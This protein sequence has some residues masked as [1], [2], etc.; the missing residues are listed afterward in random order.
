MSGFDSGPEL[1][2]VTESPADDPRDSV[3]FVHGAYVGAWCW[4]EHFLPALA[5]RGYAAH[6]VSLRGHGGSGGSL[7]GA[8]LDDFVADV[9]RAV[10]RLDSNPVLVGH[11]MGGVVVQRY[12]QRYDAPAAAL[13]ATIP[14]Q[15]MA[16]LT[17]E[18]ACRD[19]V[20]WFQ[21]G[22]LQT[23]GPRLTSPRVMRRA[24]F[25]DDLSDDRVDAY[26]RL[27]QRESPRVLAELSGPA[28]TGRVPRGLPTLVLGAADDAIVP[29]W[30]TEA[31]ARA[32][33]TDPT[34]VEDVAHAV[35]LDT[36]WER[37]E[38]SLAGWLDRLSTAR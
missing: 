24:L 1:E 27:V 16:G 25:S 33:G 4:A 29:A 21:F 37:A 28:V 9:R 8:G 31:T 32:F 11:S 18:F 19:P 15:G 26:A 6:A 20:T 3:L 12:L 36:R 22:L 17:V 34:F 7:V 30:A 13:V 23:A 2:L 38:A 35:M 5:A 14:P 10:E